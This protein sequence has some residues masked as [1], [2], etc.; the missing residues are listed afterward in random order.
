ML[1]KLNITIDGEHFGDFDIVNATT[2]IGRKSDNDIVINYPLMSSRH[3]KL[4]SVSSDWFI[5]DLGS[6]NGTYINGQSIK[7][8]SLTPSDVISIGNCHIK[9][10]LVDGAMDDDEDDATVILNPNPQFIQGESNSGQSTRTVQTNQASSVSAT[11]GMNKPG[12]NNLNG[13]LQILNGVN[14]GKEMV[15]TKQLTTIGKPNVQVAAITKRVQGYF[16]IHVDGKEN[17]IV[18]GNS[19]GVQATQLYDHDLIEVAGIKMEFFLT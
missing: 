7:K 3:C 17:P 1:G 8:T 18:N 4:I 6:T 16:I 2:S 13:K 9:L 10:I 5:E 12:M 19:V 15:L 14:S 11:M